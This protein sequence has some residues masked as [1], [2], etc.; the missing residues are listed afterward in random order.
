MA[1]IT[2]ELKWLKAVLTSLGVSHDT[3][4]TLHCDSQPTLHI[5]RNPVFH[6]HTKHIQVDCHFVCD[7]VVNGNI[8]PVF[9]PTQHQLAN[10]FT[11]VLGKAQYD[12]ILPKLVIQDL[13][14]S[15]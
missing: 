3:S 14:A 9:V 4:I 13:H 7:E 1:T 11:K 5:A 6:E 15:T 2:C 8:Q 12:T 10:I